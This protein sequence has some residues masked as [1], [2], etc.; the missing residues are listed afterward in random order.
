MR[1]GEIAT[2]QCR[3]VRKIT[4]RLKILNVK[5]KK[6]HDRQRDK[7][8]DYNV[9]ELAAWSRKLDPKTSIIALK[10]Q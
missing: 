6:K 9:P 7:I 2:K 8:N 10:L 4:R 3:R 5:S 1:N